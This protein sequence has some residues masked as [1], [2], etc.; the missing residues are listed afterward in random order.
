METLDTAPSTDRLLAGIIAVLAFAALAVQPLLGDGSY[1]QNLGAMLRFFTIWGNVG[2]CIV[3]ACI[4]LGWSVSEPRSQGILAA[5]ATALAI[6]GGIYWG[7]LSGEHHPN[8]YDRITNQFHHTII[9]LATIIWWLRFT[10]PTRPIKSVIPAIMIPP[11]SYGAF[12][13]M[14]GQMTGFYAYFFVDLPAL[15]SPQFLLN[16][17]LLAGFFALA[18]AGLVA[19]KNALG[20]YRDS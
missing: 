9:P 4:A 2:A 3:M 18:G 8:G 5:L 1:V 19:I 7:L 11:L 13:L 10:P 17:V 20:L 14:L 6:I 16:N 12:A 15:G